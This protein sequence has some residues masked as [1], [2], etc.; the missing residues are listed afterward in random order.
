[1]PSASSDG[2]ADV[3]QLVADLQHPLVLGGVPLEP[4]L[5]VVAVLPPPAASVPTAWMCPLGHGQIQ[6][7]FQAGGIASGL[8]PV[9]PVVLDQDAVLS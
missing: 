3:G 8:D 2:V 1:M 7:S 4:P 5:V 6:T 9:Q